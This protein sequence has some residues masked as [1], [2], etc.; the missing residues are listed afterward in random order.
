VATKVALVRGRYLAASEVSNYPT[1][2]YEVIAFGAEGTSPSFD[3][4]V[5]FLYNSASVPSSWLGNVARTIQS[6]LFGSSTS[7][8]GLVDELAEFDIV[9]TIETFQG[10]SEQAIKAKQKH[11]CRVVCT[12]FENIPYFAESDHYSRTWKEA[13]KHRNADAIKETVRNGAD[14]FLAMSDRA[15]TALEIEGVPSERIH[16]VPLGVDTGRFAPGAAEDT[17]LPGELGCGSTLDVVYVGRYTWEKG[18][19]DLLAAWKRVCETVDEE[20]RL[21]TVGWGPDRER[22]KRFVEHAAIPNVTICDAVEYDRIQVVYDAADLTVVPS[23]STRAWQEQYGRVITE[24]QACGTPVVASRTGGI[25][26]VISEYGVLAQ[27]GDPQDWAAKVSDLLRDRSRREQLGRESRQYVEANRTIENTA[28][29][30]EAV[31]EAIL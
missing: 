8:Y 16:V 2:N 28:E 5:R 20:V 13:L 3:F 12:V 23:L 24:S 15:K 11:G 17:S 22:I 4:P 14:A 1:S 30:I 6:L 18:I 29:Q 25:P 10:F 27:P 9:N 26:Y 19:Y 7:L 21:T 31:Y